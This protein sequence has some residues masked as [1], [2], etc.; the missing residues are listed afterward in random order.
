MWSI[1]RSEV[2]ACL[3]NISDIRYRSPACECCPLFPQC[4]LILASDVSS[5]S[6]NRLRSI[7][8]YQTPVVGV[9]YVSSCLQ[10]GV[11]LPVDGYRLD[12]SSPPVTKSNLLSLD[13][14]PFLAVYL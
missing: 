3:I 12:A 14:G 13:L 8:K 9:D 1:S 11:L 2:T 6:T 4:S 7:Q 5:L 10:S